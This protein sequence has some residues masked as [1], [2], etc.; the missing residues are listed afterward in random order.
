KYRG[1]RP[2]PGYPACPDHTEKG[3][4]FE[5]LGAAQ[6]GMSLTESYAMLPAASVSGF[7]LAHPQARYFAVGA[8]GED[9]ATDYARRKALSIEAAG[10]WLAANL[11][12]P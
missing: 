2:A 4:L 1:I 11:V 10:R 3:A 5:L 6:I 9:Q 8:V 12:S 7:Y